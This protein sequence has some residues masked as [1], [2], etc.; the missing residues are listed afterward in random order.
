MCC[1]HSNDISTLQ[2]AVKDALKE[3]SVADVIDKARQAERYANAK[4][5]VKSYSS[6]KA[7]IRFYD[8]VAFDRY[9][10]TLTGIKIFLH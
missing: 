10:S 7:Y 8:A 4:R 6:K 3:T 2:L 5:I 1:S 9:A